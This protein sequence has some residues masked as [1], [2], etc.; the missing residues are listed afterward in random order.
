MNTKVDLRNCVPGQKLVLKH[1]ELA[2][3]MGKSNSVEYPHL[4]KYPPNNEGTR[5]DDGHVF[6][7]SQKPDDNDVVA[8]IPDLKELKEETLLEL[9]KEIKKEIKR[10]KI[11]PAVIRYLKD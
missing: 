11:E 3:Y 6:R 5:I 4:I 1:G 7:I 9:V 2:T 8:V 10:K